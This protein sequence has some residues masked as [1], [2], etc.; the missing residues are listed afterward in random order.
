MNV[1]KIIFSIIFVTLLGLYSCSSAPEP[2]SEP[3]PAPVE[4][5]TPAPEPAEEPVAEPAEPDELEITEELYNK[6]FD[7]I[8]AFITEMDRVI[9]K[10]DF[11][12]WME[13]LSQSYKDTYS[14]KEV[15]DKKSESPILQM[16]NIKLKSIKD[17]FM[18]VVVPSR[19]QL[20]LE[21]IEFDDMDRVT[22]WTSFKG[23]KTKLYQLELIDGT[24][25][26]SLW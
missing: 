10:K 13:N 7:E 20:E 5:V 26:I 18:E 15:L 12:I 17:Y 8:N 25:K 19:L 23:N 3:E 2:T 16:N 14:D 22:A 11:T 1:Y 4:E 21:E 6:T 24:W 9:A